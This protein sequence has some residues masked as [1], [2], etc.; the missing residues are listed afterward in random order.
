[1][2]HELVLVDLMVS[3]MD[4]MGDLLLGTAKRSLPSRLDVKLRVNNCYIG[5]DQLL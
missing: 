3:H 2:Q 4:V 5:G 1:M